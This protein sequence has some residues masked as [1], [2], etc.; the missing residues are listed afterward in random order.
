VGRFSQL[1]TVR[2]VNEEEARE[3]ARREL[4]SEELVITG[5]SRISETWV[6]AYNS[7]TYVETGD[8]L[9]LLT[10]PGPI[11]VSDSGRV[12]RAEGSPR[13]T[14]KSRRMTQAESVAEFEQQKR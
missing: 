10:G 2:V 8:V 4:A 14:S 1:S 5:T 12:G 6:V 11:F 13:R 9:E 3:L 7:R